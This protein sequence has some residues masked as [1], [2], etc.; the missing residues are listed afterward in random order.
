MSLCDEEKVPRQGKG[1]GKGKEEQRGK[2]RRERQRRRV[3]DE[4]Q[5][6]IDEGE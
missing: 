3:G 1:R 5:R 4:V 2:R 6:S